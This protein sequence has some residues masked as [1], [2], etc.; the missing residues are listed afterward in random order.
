MSELH[1]FPHSMLIGCATGGTAADAALKDF[2]VAWCIC[3]RRTTQPLR[4]RVAR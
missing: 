2:G 3:E 1:L 4:D